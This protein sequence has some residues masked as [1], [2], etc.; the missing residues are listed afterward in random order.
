M[1]LKHPIAVL[2]AALALAACGADD[3]TTSSVTEVVERPTN[4]TLPITFEHE[5]RYSAGASIERV[6]LR[7]SGATLDA[8]SRVE[9]RLRAAP[10]DGAQVLRTL[11]D[12]RDLPTTAST[13]LAAEFNRPLDELFDPDMDGDDFANAADNCPQVPNATQGDEDGDGV[14]DACDDARSDASAG[15]DGPRAGFPDVF[16]VWSVVVSPDGYPDGGVQL[17]TTLEGM[18]RLELGP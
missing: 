3:A 16:V 8:F 9:I 17:E 1:R 2:S 12:F 7:A 11:V 4:A 13:S 10:A 5:L 14:G 6:S 15:A 18:G